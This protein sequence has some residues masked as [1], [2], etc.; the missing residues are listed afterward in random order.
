MKLGKSK[1]QLNRKLIQ[2]KISTL[3]NIQR[4]IF[5]LYIKR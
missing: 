2:E 3:R 4:E 5:G 1:A